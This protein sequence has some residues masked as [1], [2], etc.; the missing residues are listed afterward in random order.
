MI[1]LPKNH[2]IIV[3]LTYNDLFPRWI[4]RVVSAWAKPDLV[5]D[6]R[7]LMPDFWC[8]ISDVRFLMP[9]F[10]CQ[11]SDARFLMSDFWCQI[12]EARSL[13]SDFWCQISD[14]RFM[15]SDLSRNGEWQPFV[16]IT[17]LDEKNDLMW[18]FPENVIIDKLYN[19]WTLYM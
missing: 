6:V 13:M 12:S 4:K 16:V 7:F 19:I 15:M 8:Q 17:L 1:Q 14:A 9:D 5:S 10:W 11:I 18:S 3:W 2:T